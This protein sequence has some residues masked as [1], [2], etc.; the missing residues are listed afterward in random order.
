MKMYRGKVI[1][2]P[3]ISHA[4]VD[5]LDRLADF[6]TFTSFTTAFFLACAYVHAVRQSSV[7]F[8]SDLQRY[9]LIFLIP[10]RCTQTVLTGTAV[11]GT[12]WYSTAVRSAL[13]LGNFSQREEASR[14][15]SLSR[16]CLPG[17]VWERRT[18]GARR[19][20]CF[21]SH[22]SSGAGLPFLNGTIPTLRSH[23]VGLRVCFCQESVGLRGSGFL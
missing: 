20:G 16:A 2:G 17:R 15:K 21:C 6:T 7:L 4:H 12:A 1:M 5:P 8:T 19:L 18:C 3:R 14:L 10:E 13:A 22:S 11:P 23:V 9:N